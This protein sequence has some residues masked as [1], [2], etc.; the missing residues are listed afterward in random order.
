MQICVACKKE[1][2]CIKGGVK[3]IYSK[4]HVYSGDLFG[5]NICGNKT[6]VTATIPFN[7]KNPITPDKYDIVMDI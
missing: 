5:C 6:I 1:M 4:Y 7:P 3:V 2:Q